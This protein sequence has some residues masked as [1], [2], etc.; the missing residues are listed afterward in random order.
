MPRDSDID[1]DASDQDEYDPDQPLRERRAIQ[2]GLRSLHEQVTQNHDDFLEAK[3][4]LFNKLMEESNVLLDRTKQTTEATVDS[5]LMLEIADLANKRSALYATGGAGNGVDVDELV[6]KCI[7]YM[8]QGKGIGND[9]APELSSTQ[10]QRRAAN[11][12]GGVGDEDDEVGDE[13][14]MLNWAHFG[15]YACLPVLRRPALP[16][17]L[18]GPL[19]VEKKARK[20]VQRTAR[21]RVNNLR[22]TRPEVLKAEDISKTEKSDVPALC[23]KILRTLGEVQKHLQVK[24]EDASEEMDEEEA[25]NYMYQVGLRP[26]GGVD[27]LRFVVNPNSFAQTVENIFHLSFLIRD[28]NVGLGFDGDEMPSLCELACLTYAPRGKLTRIDVPEEE[29][30]APRN[31]S[32]MKHQAIISI[33]EA[34][35]R[36]IVKTYGIREPMIPHRNEPDH[37]GPGARAWYS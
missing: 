30:G 17:F 1:D 6:S 11:N 18:L 2:R 34:M 20:V 5:R 36:D 33:D 15:Q 7:T 22:E 10:R 23:R 37:R 8:R 3:P 9:S 21:L 13:G 27:L 25:R 32:A 14:D 29:D 19:S 26:D 35:W 28:G 16:G 24:V 31:R 12:R 4:K